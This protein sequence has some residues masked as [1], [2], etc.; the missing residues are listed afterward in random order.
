MTT[1]VSC[2]LPTVAIGV[3]TRA[4]GTTEKILYIGAFTVLFS[5]GLIYLTIDT[6]RLQIFAATAA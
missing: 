5:M 6:S 1:V 4:N 3:L 2:L